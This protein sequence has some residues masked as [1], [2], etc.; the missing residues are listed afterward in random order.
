MKPKKFLKLESTGYKI[1]EQKE[2][3][4]RI[5]KQSGLYF[6]AQ[7]SEI[8]FQVAIPISVGVLTGVWLDQKLTTAPLFTLLL[9][10]VGILFAFL[11]LFNILRLFGNRK[12]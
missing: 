5:P 9:L 12:K 4:R 2:T 7:A 11:A 8:G 10:G 6:L 3:S 1:I